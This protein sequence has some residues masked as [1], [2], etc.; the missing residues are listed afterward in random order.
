MANPR[1]AWGIDIGNRALKAIKLTRESSGQ[2][3]LSDFEVI[4]HET[5]LSNAGDNRD[6][7]IQSALAHFVQKHP[8]KKAAVAVSVSGSNSLAR[9]IKLPP[10][11]PK[12]IPEI[13][14]F[15]A[16]Q[17]IPFALDDVEWSYQLFRA[18]DSP[19]VEVGIFAM[20][21]DLINHQIKAYTDVGLNVEAVQLNPLAVYNAMYFDDRVAG[22]AT[23][24][25]DVGAENTDLIIADGETVW[26]RSIPVGGKNFTEILVKDFKL[27][28][29][30][31]EELKRTAA[32]SKYAKQIF[33]K[34]R[35]VFA[36]LVAEVQR[37]IGFYASVHRESKLKRVLALGGTFLLPGLQKYLQQNLQLEVIRIDRL[38]AGGPGESRRNVFEENL[39]SMASAYGLA[40]QAMGDAKITSSLLPALIRREKLW[41][42]KNPWF[43]AAAACFVV[44]SGVA[45]GW[46]GL[47]QLQWQQNAPSREKTSDVLQTANMLDGNWSNQVE[48][49]GA[50][51]SQQIAN[52]QGMVSFRDFWP[53]LTSE[54]ESAVPTA[55]NVDPKTTARKDRDIIQIESITSVYDTDVSKTTAAAAP[56]APG[57]P[58]VAPVTPPTAQMGT[59]TITLPTEFPNLAAN[60]I[61]AGAHGFILTI[62]LTTPYGGNEVD[63]LRFVDDSFVQNLKKLKDK[64]AKEQAAYSLVYAE[65]TRRRLVGE[66]DGYK[67]ALRA[68][69]DN[70]QKAIALPTTGN[71]GAGTP[72]VNPT[73]TSGTTGGFNGQTTGGTGPADANSPIIDP[74]NANN[75]DM[76]NDT[77]LEVTAIVLLNPPAPNPS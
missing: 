45:L 40:I 36:D 14:R 24:I 59:T 39:L 58:A 61:P 5:L 44:G 37:S 28:F 26:L 63:A 18:P 31:A 64:Q 69:L 73:M 52:I 43:A 13:V 23:M 32:T 76:S 46:Y 25:I 60:L 15:E 68:R 27:S 38:G 55:K 20:R 51:D 10:V 11:E 35:Q 67:T 77:I 2:L 70:W 22:G 16:I 74:S 6:S 8:E 9:F 33:Q 1:S 50:G 53:K 48:A 3:R 41:K 56:A 47:Q 54:I 4:E 49:A 12:K 30:K 21:K 42:D 7:L 72:A 62:R 29:A 66:D 75:E 19:D 34:M 17:Q 57:A 65:V 71:G